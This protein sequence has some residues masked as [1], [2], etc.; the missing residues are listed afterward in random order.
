[1]LRI[2]GDYLLKPTTHL[3]S[4]TPP[5]TSG[6]VPSLLA[7]TIIL[8]QNLQFFKRKQRPLRAVD[9]K[10]QR[11]LS[12]ISTE[13]FEKDKENLIEKGNADGDV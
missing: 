13:Y 12:K 11:I 5:S 3:G 8:A 9:R 6:E 4:S 10:E 1:M 2:V 7:L